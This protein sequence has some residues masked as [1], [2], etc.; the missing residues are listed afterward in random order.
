MKN[1]QSL[2]PDQII[3][4]IR[5]GL[6]YLIAGFQQIGFRK[7]TKERLDALEKQVALLSKK[8]LDEDV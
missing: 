6:N 3:G 4:L 5:E 2:P 7:T 8:A 1:L